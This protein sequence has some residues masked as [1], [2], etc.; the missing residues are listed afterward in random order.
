MLALNFFAALA[1]SPDVKNSLMTSPMHRRSI[2]DASANMFAMSPDHQKV[3]SGVHREYIAS[4]KKPSGTE[5]LLSALV[6]M[7][8]L[9][10]LYLKVK[11]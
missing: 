8:V 7:M 3:T 2:A 1:M 9:D 11:T 10:P 5:P 6:E 4:V